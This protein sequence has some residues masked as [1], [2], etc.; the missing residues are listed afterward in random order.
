MIPAR[1][2]STASVVLPIVLAPW[3]LA[4]QGSGTSH[5]VVHRGTLDA[6]TPAPG[7]LSETP[8]EAAGAEV[9]GRIEA[10]RS[11]YV[12]LWSLHGER[13]AVLSLVVASDGGLA[14]DLPSPL[15]TAVY[16][17]FDAGGERLFFAE[18]I[19]GTFEHAL[20]AG[21]YVGLR[22]DLRLEDPAAGAFVRL[23][24]FSVT[25][26]P[27]VLPP[28]DEGAPAQ[29]AGVGVGARA[30]NGG[31]EDDGYES[32]DAN[33][34]AWQGSSED[35]GGCDGDTGTSST[36]ESEGSGCEGDDLE[37][38]STSDDDAAGD[39]CDGDASAAAVVAAGGLT[40]GLADG[41]TDRPAVRRRSPV[42]ARLVAWLPYLLV[43]GL[44]PLRRARRRLAIIRIFR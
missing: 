8:G 23:S 41:S 39:S 36:D 40:G 14:L 11:H 31:C 9:V 28:V 30:S 1:A 34:P 19:D 18:R 5:G 38:G 25:L 33:D 21:G 37:S 2:R 32:S 16:E 35:S 20:R 17:E 27:D 15:V 4:W 12:L 22:L 24:D 26:V 6:P 29:P 7:T 44:L 43:L 42:V 13:D 10:G 3:L